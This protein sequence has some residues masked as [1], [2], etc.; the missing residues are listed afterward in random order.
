MQIPFPDGGAT[1]ESDAWPPSEGPPAAEL[2]PVEPP[3]ANVAR[4]PTRLE[5]ILIALAVLACLGIARTVFLPILLACMLTMTLKPWI[6]WLADH[7]IPRPLSA[8][9]VLA[10]VV[11]GVGEAFFHLGRPAVQWVDDAPQ[12]LVEL[13]QRVQK[14]VPLI[15]RFS[16]V[17]TAVSNLGATEEERRAEQNKTPTV[18]I[19]DGHGATVILNWTGML[20]VGIGETLVLAYL[21]LASGDLFL[22]KLVHAMPTMSD[23]KRAVVISREIQQNI[24]NYFFSISLINLGLGSAVSLGLWIMDVPNPVMWGLFAALL[25]Y[26]PY[27]GPIIGVAT[28]GIV[29]VLAFDSVWA[30][31]LPLGWYLALHL[32]EANFVTPILLGRRFTLNPVVIFASL[33]FWTWLWGVP[34]ALLSGPILV[35]LK[36]VCDRMPRLNQ[37]GELL[38][39]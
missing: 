6:N 36:V 19:K 15:T 14:V 2:V 32:L 39:G 4:K 21:L 38:A 8:A 24:S 23:K 18:Q 37:L 29:G 5:I 9:V 33:L 1:E 11:A 12:H 22:Q 27:F 7:W 35:S 17:A 16:P 31:L 13:R 30:G 10:V 26:L 25:N 34:G 3:P 20:L 28:L